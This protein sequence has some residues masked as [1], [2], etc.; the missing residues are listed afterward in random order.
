MLALGLRGASV[1]RTGCSSGATRSS[2]KKGVM[3][4]LLH[5]VPVGDDSV[6]HRVLKGEDTPLGLSLVTDVG[7]LLSHSDHH[8]LVA[9]AAHDGRE[10][11][12]GSVVTGEPGLAHA[13]AVVHN[14]S[15][16]ILVTHFDFKFVC[17]ECWNVLYHGVPGSVAR[18]G[19][20]M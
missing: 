16:D 7:V 2:L 20:P 6:L 10:D 5:V 19:I 3:P 9:G 12:A 11:G 17:T 18:G 8:T 4:D 13:G 14:Q 15:S 1:R